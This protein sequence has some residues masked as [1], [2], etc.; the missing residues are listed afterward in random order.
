MVTNGF[1][2]REVRESM[3]GL[4]DAVNVDLKSFNEKYYKKNLGGKLEVILDNLKF[5]VQKGIHTEVTTLIVPTQNDSQEEI[6]KI[7]SFIA[8]ELGS[9]IPWHISAFHPDY[10]EMELPRTPLETL[11]M[12]KEIGYS[13]GLENIHIG[14]VGG[15][16]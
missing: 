6:E 9:D 13:K 15:I 4:I 5:F 16:L 8:D 10:K 7:A 2:S 1:Q 14:N 12:A 3:V 11:K